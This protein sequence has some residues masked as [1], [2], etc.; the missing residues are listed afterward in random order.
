MRSGRIAIND[1][2]LGVVGE[3]GF[4]WSSMA[5]TYESSTIATAYNLTFIKTEVNPSYNMFGRFYGRPLRC[6]STVL[7]M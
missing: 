7:G 4:G 5:S 1:G 2:W 6:L 3:W